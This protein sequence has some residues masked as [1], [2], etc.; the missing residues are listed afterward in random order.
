MFDFF[1]LGQPSVGPPNQQNAEHGEADDADDG[2]VCEWD[3]LLL[4]L[5]L[6]LKY[7]MI[8]I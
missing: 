1:G 4:W 7:R 6:Y 3:Q 5:T 8:L 2:N